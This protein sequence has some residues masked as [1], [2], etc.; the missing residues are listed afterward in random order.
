MDIQCDYSG[1]LSRYFEAMFYFF[2]QE[3]VISVGELNIFYFR[4]VL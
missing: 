4:S 1:I 3:F 2:V